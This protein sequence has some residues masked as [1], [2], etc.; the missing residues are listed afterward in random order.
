MRHP[1]L[2]RA[3]EHAHTPTVRER[4]HAGRMAKDPALHHRECAV[5]IRFLYDL[6]DGRTALGRPVG[7]ARGPGQ[8]RCSEHR[9]RAT[10]RHVPSP[11]PGPG[12]PPRHVSAKPT[13]PRKATT[14]STS[15]AFRSWLASPCPCARDTHQIPHRLTS[16]PTVTRAARSRTAFIIPSTAE[17]PSVQS[18]P[19]GA[20]ATGSPRGYRA[21]SDPDVPRAPNNRPFQPGSTIAIEPPSQAR[22]PVITSQ[23]SRWTES[24]ITRDVGQVHSEA[25]ARPKSPGSPCSPARGRRCRSLSRPRRRPS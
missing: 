10:R 9:P 18:G 1:E 21:D 8:P 14:A 12:G 16:E 23:K 24:Q 4:V 20:G 19:G 7:A 11:P 3:L 6:H 2:A 15:I 13:R 17:V 25:F 22:V 5:R